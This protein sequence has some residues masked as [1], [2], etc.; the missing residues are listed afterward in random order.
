[1]LDF[2]TTL[3]RYRIEIRNLIFENKNRR[4]YSKKIAYLSIRNI[5]NSIVTFRNSYMISNSEP[6][7]FSKYVQTPS[8][9]CLKILI[10]IRKFIGIKFLACR[11]ATKW[12]LKGIEVEM[13][14]DTVQSWSSKKHF[15]TN[16]ARKMSYSLKTSPVYFT[17]LA[18]NYFYWSFYCNYEIVAFY[19]NSWLWRSL[20]LINEY[21]E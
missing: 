9:I 20:I 10:R 21:F 19:Y 6:Q 8:E 4:L 2:R 14:V 18:E 5:K 12:N 1:M 17:K 16:A 13:T 11:N 15:F 7:V 3:Y